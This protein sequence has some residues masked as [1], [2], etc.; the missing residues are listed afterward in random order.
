MLLWVLQRQVPEID[1][2]VPDRPV[3]DTVVFKFKGIKFDR[4]FKVLFSCIQK[5]VLF[6]RKQVFFA[7]R[8]PSVRVHFHT[9]TKDAEGRNNG[10]Q[11]FIHIRKR[12]FHIPG[13]Q[14]QHITACLAGLTEK[15]VSITI[16]P[17][18]TQVLVVVKWTKNEGLTGTLIDRA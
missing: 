15:G 7:D 9:F 3:F 2:L 11:Q 14:L 8:W 17:A 18:G 4:D 10:F 6:S 13:C 16:D 5:L 12:N 1:F